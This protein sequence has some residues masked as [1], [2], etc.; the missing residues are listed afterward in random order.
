MTSL[1]GPS[2]GDQDRSDDT[3]TDE[4]IARFMRVAVIA[5]LAAA[6]AFSGAIFIFVP[7]QTTRHGGPVVAALVI[8][9]VHFLLRAG[10]VRQAVLFLSGGIW[11]AATL[12]GFVVGAPNTPIL[13]IYPVLTV[14]V[15]W[16]YSLRAAIVMA[17]ASIAMLVSIAY[18]QHAGWLGG[19]PP[20][21]AAMY[22]V[23]QSLMIVLATVLVIYLVRANQEQVAR[24]RRMADAIAE[25]G[26]ELEASKAELDRAQGVGK[27][28]SWVLDFGTATMRLSAE[29]CRIFGLPAGSAGSIDACLA[30]AHE[31]DR[32]AM[33]Q[34][35]RE[36]LEGGIFDHEYRIDIGGETR[37][38]RQRAELEYDAA[39]RAST[40]LGVIQDITERKRQEAEIV[41]A[42][43]QLQ[44]T[45][46]AIPDLM[47]E[48][49][50]EGRYIDYHSPRT[51]L[52]AAPPEQLLGRLIEDML[53]PEAARICMEALRE[54]GEIG[55]SAGR[56]FALPLPQGLRWFELSVARKE[57]VDGQLARFVVLSR[58]I[59]ERK[60][61]EQALQGHQT[62][63]EAEVAARTRELAAARDAAEAASLAKSAFL[64]NVS[65]EI[66]TPMNAIVGL[67]YL[68]RRAPQT[69]QQAER[70]GKI[71][72][73]ARHLLGII[74]DILD[75]SRSEAGLLVPQQEDFSLTAMM[76]QL[77]SLLG[78][79]ARAKDIALEIDVA[80]VPSWLRGDAARLRQALF[81][82][83]GNAIKFT[84]QGRVVLRAS[85]IEEGS[86]GLRLRFEVEDTGIGIAAD[87]LPRLFR[88]F[89]QVDASTTRRYG[90]AGLGL[91]IARRLAEM[92]GGEVGAESTPGVGSRFWF[93]VRLQRGHGAAPSGE[94]PAP[95]ID[96]GIEVEAELRR[97]HAGARLLV[98]E[99]NDVNRE[100][101]LELLGA[102]G[103]R[104]DLAWDGVEA[105]A[106]A[107]T[108]DYA[109]ILMDLQMPRMDGIEATRAI[110]AL[111]G[112]AGVPILAM[113]ANA[114]SEDRQQSFAAG[115]NDFV[116]KPV[117]PGQLYATLLKWLPENAS[118]GLPPAVAAAPVRVP[119]ASGPSELP[120]IPGVDMAYGL[121][122]VRGN[123]AT[124]RKLLG[125]FVKSHGDAAA[126][127][128]Q[129][130]V[131]GDVEG[132]RRVAHSLKGAA[133]ALGATELA[134]AAAALDAALRGGQTEVDQPTARL[135]AELDRVIGGLRRAIA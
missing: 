134:Q 104:V 110:R 114:Y 97:R 88:P 8:V 35:W 58:D 81:N 120:A 46:D 115:M 51:E 39:G 101:A 25:R 56:Q 20:T 117:S 94:T 86:D 31:E 89:E 133:G 49:D 50:A 68:L 13:A 54:A 55:Y 79:A 130:R 135:L 80:G 122:L 16:A 75:V 127:I 123:V 14:F 19:F 30:R 121:G 5:G 96:A 52:L 37:W 131:G 11:L 32:P 105:V 43:N 95:P 109:L 126:H 100:V 84:K 78:E 85:V 59:T 67:S 99:D 98:A 27:T 44:A 10:R 119:P 24:Q 28:G 41:E 66:R 116:A 108:A 57:V 113:T 125:M 72:E 132:V 111:P 64:A 103:F 91:V 69:P 17:L 38:I 15:G 70:L 12:I 62:R 83:A 36:A 107:R 47:F 129:L 48:I 118:P 124:Y 40:V 77:R 1:P 9:G 4:F 71:D 18:A 2:P 106:R 45:L 33:E 21:P 65:H 60:E 128:E 42:R 102:P 22:V 76:D 34:A 7:E 63:L 74:N 53:P 73:A 92:M 3:I 26:R 23:A 29:A 82:Y 112:Y 61:S 90:G 6:A 93:S 87:M